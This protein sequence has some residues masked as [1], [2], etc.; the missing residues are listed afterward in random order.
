MNL[1]HQ[2]RFGIELCG[3]AG[4]QVYR[5]TDEALVASLE[6]LHQGL[7]TIRAAIEYRDGTA[8]ESFA[9]SVSQLSGVCRMFRALVRVDHQLAACDLLLQERKHRRFTLA[10]RD[11]RG[12]PVLEQLA[13]IA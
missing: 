5:I 4:T 11:G 3:D 7:P 13:H 8:V 6:R 10:H 1:L 2:I 12:D 9:C